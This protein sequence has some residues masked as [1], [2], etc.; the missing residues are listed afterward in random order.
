MM[1]LLNHAGTLLVLNFS[2]SAS[3]ISAIHSAS[4]EE[5]SKM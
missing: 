3:V 2:F 4:V 1:S 5:L